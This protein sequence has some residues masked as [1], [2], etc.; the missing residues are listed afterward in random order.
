MLH[1][2]FSNVIVII[3]TTSVINKTVIKTKCTI[4]YQL[5]TCPQCWETLHNI[6]SKQ[7][8]TPQLKN[9][10]INNTYLTEKAQF[11]YF[12]RPKTKQRQKQITGKKNCI[13][14]KSLHILILVVSDL[15]LR[16]KHYKKRTYPTLKQVI[17][18]IEKMYQQNINNKW[19]LICSQEKNTRCTYRTQTQVL[20][21]FKKLYL[22]KTLTT[23][24]P[25]KAQVF[26][27]IFIK[28]NTNLA[29]I[30]GLASVQIP[31]PQS[32]NKSKY[33]HIVTA[34]IKIILTHQRSKNAMV[35]NY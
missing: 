17:L 12:L 29:K 26:I 4:E 31:T 22:K 25:K 1:V 10:C 14:T 18:I 15:L 33:M 16:E 6:K 28:T 11:K 27:V 32:P 30:F 9:T 8:F 23:N 3:I 24:R 13:F 34:L 20:I 21:N 19:Y 35:I 2:N 7:F 5:P